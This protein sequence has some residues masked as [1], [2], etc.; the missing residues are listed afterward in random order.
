MLASI[1]RINME[2]LQLREKEIFETLKKLKEFE[3]VVIGGYSVN[4]YTL[5]RFSVDCDIVIKSKDELKDIEEAI[6]KINYKKEE[7]NKNKAFYYGNF[8]RY[9]KDLGKGFRVS[10]DI[11]IK[12]VLD[13]Q[14]NTVFSS[15]WI[16]E[17]SGIRI[18]KGKTINEELKLRIINPDALMVMKI[19]NCRSTD[20]RD[21]FML[22]SQIKDKKWIKEEISKRYNF[23]DRL[24][25]IKEKINSKQF[26]DGLQGIYGIID[27]KI[28]EKN[29]KIIL[30]LR[31]K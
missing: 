21:V 23:D 18:L 5:P 15:D 9:E 1:W 29:K 6:K 3:F 28:F 4:A 13:R 16:F 20:I 8:C 7:T 17:N 26:K 12:E 24:S 11:L 14:T 25:K 22:A 30:S 31:E 10:I 27:S 19:I 2:L